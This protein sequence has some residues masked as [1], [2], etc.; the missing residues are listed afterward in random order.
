MLCETTEPMTRV[1][2]L[3]DIHL[4]FLRPP[5]R[6]HFLARVADAR[7]DAVLLSGD[8]GEA[9]DVVAFLRQIALAWPFPIY[10]VLG[11]HDFYFGSIDD[12]R[13]RVQTLCQEEPRL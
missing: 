9:H 11:N 8:I 3:T 5:E 6:E 10:F 1:A 13:Q 7:P 2:W 12:V 4:N